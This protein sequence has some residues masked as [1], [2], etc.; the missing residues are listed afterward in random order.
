MVNIL[1]EDSNIFTHKILIDFNSSI[2]AGIFPNNLKLA[3]LTPAYKKG[4]Q[5][6]KCSYIPVRILPTLSKIYE[7][8]LHDQRGIF[9]ESKL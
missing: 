9:V 1:K 5:I 6:E 8:L 3:D 2:D 4:E 7:H